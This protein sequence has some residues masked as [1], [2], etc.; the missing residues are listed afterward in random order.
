MGAHGVYSGNSKEVGDCMAS[1]PL[2][3]AKVVKGEAETKQ[4]E[5]R[6]QGVKDVVGGVADAA[7]YRA[8]LLRPRAGG[9]AGTLPKLECKER[10][11]P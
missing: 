9:A 5:N 2:G 3:L 7:T 10:L 11:P 6:T 8:G 4:S 1:L